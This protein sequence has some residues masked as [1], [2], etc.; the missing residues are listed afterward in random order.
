MDESG[1]WTQRLHRWRERIP[2]RPRRILV[3]TLGLLLLAAGVL[4]LVLPGPGL[5][6]LFLGFAV[7]ATEY[8]WA[9]RLVEPI[10]RRVEAARER[11]RVQRRGA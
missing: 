6:G 4:M 10:R 3:T 11:R 8:A 9:R 7:L 5:V 1:T 2:P